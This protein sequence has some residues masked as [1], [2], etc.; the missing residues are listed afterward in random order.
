[1]TGQVLK[2][3][4]FR[5]ERE[6]APSVLKALGW[7]R[8]GFMRPDRCAAGRKEGLQPP[9]RAF[10]VFAA[11]VLRARRNPT[12]GAGVQPAPPVLMG[13]QRRAEGTGVDPGRASVPDITTG[14]ITKED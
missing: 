2:K 12:T 9:R 5:K 14:R 6:Y 8:K 7:Q 10:G 11:A 3:S 4:S 13:R 1:V